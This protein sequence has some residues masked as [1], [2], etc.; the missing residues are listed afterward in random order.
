MPRPRKDPTIRRDEFVN[1]AVTLFS[2]KGYSGTSIRDVLAALA[3][4]SASPSVFYYYFDSKDDLYRAAIDEVVRWHMGYIEDSYGEILRVLKSD[5]PD[6]ERTETACN[7]LKALFAKAFTPM[8][9]QSSKLASRYGTI[10]SREFLAS[11]R[12]GI[13][14]RCADMWADAV[15]DLP[16][17]LPEDFNK[18]AASHFL[19]GGISQLFSSQFTSNELADEDIRFVLKHAVM[20]SCRL[21]NCP[22]ECR[23]RLIAFIDTLPLAE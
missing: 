4:R 6:A 9:T 14:E 5:L 22:V 17:E 8:K 7:K 13:A 19:A 1:V 2:E 20:I 11:V 15:A 10:K 12:F 23:D 18:E 16:W 21:C 3:D